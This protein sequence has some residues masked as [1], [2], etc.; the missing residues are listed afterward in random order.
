M[1]KTLETKKIKIN[2]NT[3]KTKVRKLFQYK[4]EMKSTILLII[5]LLISIISSTQ[6]SS[7][8]IDEPICL[9]RGQITSGS[10]LSP[11]DIEKSKSP[12][13]LESGECS[14]NAILLKPGVLV[15]GKMVPSGGYCLAN[16]ILLAGMAQSIGGTIEIGST[17][18]S[19]KSCSIKA[20]FGIG[21]SLSKGVILETLPENTPANQVFAYR[22]KPLLNNLIYTTQ[23]L[24]DTRCLDGGVIVDGL[25]IKK[26]ELVVY[27]LIS[28]IYMF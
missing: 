27:V 1:I 5:S 17:L 23:T 21:V 24:S 25:I 3:F 26:Y 14:E 12:E 13:L 10:M 28:I 9:R 7:A 6:Q 18:P 4:R 15:D 16:G 11:I 2:N 22:D 20:G 19:G 8:T